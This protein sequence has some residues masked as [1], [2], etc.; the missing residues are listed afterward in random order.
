MKQSFWKTISETARRCFPISWKDTGVMVL[1]LLCA[2]AVCTLLHL[3]SPSFNNE[4]MIFFLALML[5][6]RW[7]EGYFYDIAG[8]LLSVVLVNYAFT[9]PY[10]AVDFSLTGYPLMFL[11]MLSISI[12]VGTLTSR[13]KQRDKM[14]EEVIRE[15]MYSNL[16]RSVSHDIRTPLTSIA[17]S[18]S[19]I[20]ESGDKLNEEQRKELLCDIRD[21]AQW[22]IRVVENILSITRIGGCQSKIS[23]T[24]ELAEE[25]ISSAVGKLQKTYPEE[26]IR[27][28]LPDSVFFIEMD[29]ILIEQVLFNL[30]ENAVLHAKGHTW[31]AISLKQRE[32]DVLFTVSDNGCGIS[33][34]PK[35]FVI[36][37][38]DPEH[39]RER[40]IKRNMG[41]GLSVCKSIILAHGGTVVTENLPEG[42]AAFSFTLPM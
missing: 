33:E 17:G 42:G 7:T 22:L 14:R 29:P 15:Q 6:A 26:E 4:T 2:Y 13:A 12:M 40:D 21:E 34:K 11:V 18:T 10:Y 9:Y 3:F 25:I 16:L 32:A 41:I 23:K 39:A 27:I 28:E 31:I 30:L 24:P 36:D 38:F 5:I 19:A 8:S 20:L 35:K 1:L 37:L